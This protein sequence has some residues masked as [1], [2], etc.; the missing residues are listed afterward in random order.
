MSQASAQG[1]AESAAAGLNVIRVSDLLAPERVKVPLDSLD[2]EGI[3][4]ELVDLVASSEGL[5][6]QRDEVYQAIWEREEVL[7]TGIGEGVALPHAK[8]GGLEAM[9]MA[10]GVCREPVDFGAL[11]SEPVR[12]LFLLLSPEAAA[13]SQVR[14]LSRISRLVRDES[15]RKRLVS[16]EDAGRFL[17]VLE[18][19]ER[20]I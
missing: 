11:D 20:A 1:G 5:T 12:L 3:L 10:A 19:A 7:S 13:G 8:L 4:L 16:V 14:A 17:Q 2:K 6:T 15:L 18:D 9:V